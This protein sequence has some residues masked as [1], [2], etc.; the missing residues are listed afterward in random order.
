MEEH[1][2][3]GQ[4]PQW[5][6]VSMEEEEEG[7]IHAIITCNNYCISTATMVA[8]RCLSVTLY[9]HC[10]SCCVNDS[11]TLKCSRLLG[12]MMRD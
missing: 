9:V 1:Y 8:R 4:S 5:A 3:T 2:S 6:V 12:P 10:L 11:F 7:Y